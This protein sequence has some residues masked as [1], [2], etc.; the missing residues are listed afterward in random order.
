M[1]LYQGKGIK[2]AELWFSDYSDGS[3]IS[4]DFDVAFI[5][6]SKSP[7]GNLE[8]N[9]FYTL[10]IDLSKNMDEIEAGISKNTRYEIKRADEKDS[11]KSFFFKNPD[12]STILEFQKYFSAFAT[13]KNLGVAGINRI[14]GIASDH[15]LLLSKCQN[16]NGDVLCWHA[17][18]ARNKRMRLLYSASIRPSG[19]DS[20]S[21]RA[22]IG[23]SNRWLH[24][25]DIQFAK[26]DGYQIYDLGGWDPNPPNQAIEG[27]NKFKEGFS[28]IREESHDGVFIRT[29]KGRIY[30]FAK[31]FM[32]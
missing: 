20:K 7:L 22:L 9:K 14:K 16:D 2:I 8:K 26:N 11:L 29:M 30:L 15:S 32:G 28:Q 18:V 31:K 24:W 27:I 25:Q 23:R 17:Y 21:D 19:D 6:Q 3:I 1:I 13:Q 10:I 12:P 5:Y 4:N